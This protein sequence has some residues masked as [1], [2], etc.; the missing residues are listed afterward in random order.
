MFIPGGALLKLGSAGSKL[1]GATKTASKLSK[2]AGIAKGTEKV[3]G[4]AIKQGLV[5]GLVSGAEQAIPRG[6]I[7]GATT[8]VQTGDAGQGLQ[9]GLMTAGTGTALGGAFGAGISGLGRGVSKFG[10]TKAGQWT[11]QLASDLGNIVSINTFSVRM[12][13][14]EKY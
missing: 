7:Q 13:P 3:A 8:G 10:E 14:Q 11:K 1:L 9:E 12:V 6:L 4:G 2:L 5:R